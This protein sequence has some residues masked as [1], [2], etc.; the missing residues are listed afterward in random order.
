MSTDRYAAVME[1]DEGDVTYGPWETQG[2]AE[3]RAS[4]MRGA[5]SVARALVVKDTQQ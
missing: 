2:Q 3:D 1:D 4:A 5:Y